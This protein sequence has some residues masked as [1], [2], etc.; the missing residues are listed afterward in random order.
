MIEVTKT[1]VK[2]PLRSWLTSPAPK[3]VDIRAGMDGLHEA[4]SEITGN[5][6]IKS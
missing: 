2:K 4:V 6:S 3:R 5:A 1:P